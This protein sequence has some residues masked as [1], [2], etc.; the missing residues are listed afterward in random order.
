MS[1]S[2]LANYYS[3]IFSLVQHHKYSISD[4]ENIF[5]FERDLY[6][7]MLISFLEEKR[8]EMEQG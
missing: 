8:K 2:S 5:P 4:L 1:H 7:D 3:L 6:V